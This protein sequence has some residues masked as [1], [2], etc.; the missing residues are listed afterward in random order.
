MNIIY[1]SIYLLFRSLGLRA[2]VRRAVR[3][4]HSVHLTSLPGVRTDRCYCARAR[5][6]RPTT[7]RLLLF[8]IPEAEDFFPKI[9]Y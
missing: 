6:C 8:I 1:L 5:A 4:M 2:V 3:K 7:S 9:K